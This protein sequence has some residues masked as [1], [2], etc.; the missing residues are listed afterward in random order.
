V[1]CSPDKDLTQCVRGTHVVCLDRLRRKVIDEVAVIEK[2]GVPPGSI[3]DWLA[4][5]GDSADGFPGVPRWGG[6]S[7]SAV[8]ARFGHLESIPDDESAWGIPIRGAATLAANLREHRASAVLFKTLATLRTDA[9]IPEALDDLRWRGARREE[10]TA[11]CDEI[12][13]A[14][15]L[16]RVDRWR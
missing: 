1:I 11:L 16:E 6:K 7:A 2:F 3:A 12:G 8:L 5:V 13:D 10:L 4:L 15:F 14:G 9:P